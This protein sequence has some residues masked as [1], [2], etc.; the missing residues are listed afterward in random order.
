MEVGKETVLPPIR[1]VHIKQ[2]QSPFLMW[3]K[4]ISH[5]DFQLT[6]VRNMLAEAG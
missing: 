5:R 3:G 4:K 1:P 6:L 2:L